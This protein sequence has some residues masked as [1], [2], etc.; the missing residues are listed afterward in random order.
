MLAFG[1]SACVKPKPED[2]IQVDKEF[3]A[4]ADI[5]ASGNLGYTYGLFNI[6]TTSGNLLGRG[7]YITIWKKQTDGT[8]KYVLDGG[9]EGP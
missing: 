7:K 3:I 9:N 8:W 1:L 4:Y 2:L 6:H 5:S